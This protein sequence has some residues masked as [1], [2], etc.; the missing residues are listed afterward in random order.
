MSDMK[1]VVDELP[2]SSRDCMFATFDPETYPYCK[3][4]CARFCKLDHEICRLD[5]EEKC[6]ILISLKEAMKDI[7]NE[8]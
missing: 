3:S 7:I 1:I 5:K 2:T 8:Q 4:I 6:D